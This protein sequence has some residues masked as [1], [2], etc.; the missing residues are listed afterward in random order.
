MHYYP[1][2]NRVKSIPVAKWPMKYAG[3]DRGIGLNDFLW[4]VNDWTKSEQV[5]ESELLR[6]F[7]NLL[8]GKAKLWFTSNKHRLTT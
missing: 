2:A 5:T 7:G 4:E 6:S 1:V 8:S 3:D